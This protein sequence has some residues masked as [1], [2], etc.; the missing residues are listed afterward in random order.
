MSSFFV[1]FFVF[2]LII[3]EKRLVKFVTLLPLSIK[4]INPILKCPHNESYACI[5]KIFVC[6]FLLS[7][8]FSISFGTCSTPK[9]SKYVTLL[10]N[11]YKAVQW[12]PVSKYSSRFTTY[13]PFFRQIISRIN[14]IKSRF[15]LIILLYFKIS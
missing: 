3:C 1:V 10:F 12:V 2:V 6:M 4:S 8:N 13:S 14:T 5:L 7:V 9:L 11:A 15:I